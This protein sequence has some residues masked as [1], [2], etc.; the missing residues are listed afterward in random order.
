MDDSSRRSFVDSPRLPR[1]QLGDLVA[2]KS[3]WSVRKDHCGWVTKLPSPEKRK[4]RVTVQFADGHK[5]SYAPQN[6]RVPHNV[7]QA[8]AII[9]SNPHYVVFCNE[10]RTV[11]KKKSENIV[12]EGISAEV[13]PDF[14]TSG[15]SVNT[16]PSDYRQDPA[17]NR[18]ESMLQTL[19]Q[20]ME[21]LSVRMASMEHRFN[22]R[23]G[24]LNED[25]RSDPLD[26]Y[27]EYT[28]E[29]I[30]RGGD[31]SVV[32]PEDI[33]QFENEEDEEER[34]DDSQLTE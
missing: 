22:E 30:L 34:K 21:H 14:T 3:Q 9:E 33:A 1:W 15:V 19:V 12:D 6:L 28:R 13:P 2:V 24:Q 10:N 25:E 32:R 26:D 31:Q 20:Q 16:P 29:V 17:N 5:N 4:P 18:M 7:D 23:S 11:Q 27:S 8:W